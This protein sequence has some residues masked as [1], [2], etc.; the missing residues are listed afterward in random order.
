MA[1]AY[2]RTFVTSFLASGKEIQATIP[3]VEAVQGEGLTERQGDDSTY[4]PD[5][6]V[7]EY[8]CQHFAA[9]DVNCIDDEQV[10]KSDRRMRHRS[11]RIKSKE[12]DLEIDAA[13]RAKRQSRCFA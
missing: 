9:A 3:A 10:N 7:F 2:L 6:A 13:R 1:F 8:C 5:P 12:R 4:K 11:R